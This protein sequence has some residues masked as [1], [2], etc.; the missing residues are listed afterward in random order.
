MTSRRRR[1]A[2]FLHW[3]V[4]GSLLWLASGCASPAP[5][6]PP[7]DGSV[8]TLPGRSGVEIRGRFEDGRYALSTPDAY[9]RLPGYPFG[10]DDVKGRT[11]PNGIKEVHAVIVNNDTRQ[12]RLTYSIQWFDADGFAFDSGSSRWTPMFLAPSGTGV[13]KGTSLSGRARKFQ[14]HVREGKAESTNSIRSPGRK[15]R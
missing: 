9:R 12:L 1:R 4:A 2:T 10:V 3:V 11:H 8:R 15:N 13:I 6:A 5:A 7:G 14:I